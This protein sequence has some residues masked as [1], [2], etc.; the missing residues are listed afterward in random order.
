METIMI[1]LANN[2]GGLEVLLT[3]YWG[4]QQISKDKIA[5]VVLDKVL[6]I[7]GSLEHYVCV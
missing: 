1:P 2:K 3:A 4:R 5:T 7:P 6:R